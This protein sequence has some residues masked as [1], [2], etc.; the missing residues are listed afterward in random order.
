[1]LALRAIKTCC[2]KPFH[3]WHAILYHLKPRAEARGYQN[4]APNGAIFFKSDFPEHF[5]ISIREFDFSLICNL[6]NLVILFLA[7]FQ[8]LKIKL[9]IFLIG[10]HPSIPHIEVKTIIALRLLMVHI[11]MGR[12]IKP[13][14]EWMMHKPFWE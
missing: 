1:M 12:S 6:R 13:T 3:L 8:N 2:F 10:V 11:V 7:F 14:K 4:L 5:K 9:I